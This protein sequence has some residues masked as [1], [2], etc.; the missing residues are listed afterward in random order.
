MERLFHCQQL[1]EAFTLALSIAG[2]PGTLVSVNLHRG[3]LEIEVTT[4]QEHYSF[5][6]LAKEEYQTRN[7]SELR[8][9]RELKEELEASII[10]AERDSEVGAIVVSKGEKDASFF[11]PYC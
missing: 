2:R 5:R 7:E 1:L 10:I 9:L 4:P 11:S 3:E 6:L 8:I